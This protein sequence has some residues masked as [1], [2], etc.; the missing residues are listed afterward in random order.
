MSS[1]YPSGMGSARGATLIALSAVLAF[2]CHN[3]RALSDADGRLRRFADTL[4]TSQASHSIR[5]RL[6]TKLREHIER[7]EDCATLHR[8]ISGMEERMAAHPEEGPRCPEGKATSDEETRCNCEWA[9]VQIGA[10]KAAPASWTAVI[11]DNQL[12]SLPKAPTPG[13]V[14]EMEQSASEQA[15]KFW[16][17]GCKAPSP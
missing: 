12:D 9:W 5:H 13:F 3:P 17:L 1:H 4:A 15:S 16:T 8:L 11:R 14:A 2:G 6:C 10:A 7:T